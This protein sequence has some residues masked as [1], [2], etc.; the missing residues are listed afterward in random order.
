MKLSDRNE[1]ILKFLGWAWAIVLV[2]TAC[3]Y[4][5]ENARGWRARKL[6]EARL[7]AAGESLDLTR[8]QMASVPAEEN[9]RET[10]ALQSL[11][12]EWP[13][14]FAGKPSPPLKFLHELSQ[15]LYRKELRLDGEAVD[16]AA[17]RAACTGAFAS[18]LS[19]DAT[20]PAR[21]VSGRR[22]SNP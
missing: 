6:A 11:G 8:F 5:V 2:V 10:P 21:A 12:R 3:F 22:R 13:S 4:L 15:H 16:W 7:T 1:R 9:F 14:S 19:D 17:W 20:D 18:G